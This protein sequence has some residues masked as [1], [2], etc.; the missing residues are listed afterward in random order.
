MT[1][2]RHA[3]IA[4]LAVALS[5]P[6]AGASA[7]ECQCRAN[8]SAFRQG[9]TTCLALPDGPRLARCEMV[10][11]NSS[12]KILDQACLQTSKHLEREN[13]MTVAHYGATFGG[14]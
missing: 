13:P 4:A 8:G 5:L 10:L 1:M 6:V 7:A 11:N 12:W 3:G 2:L 9:E 14:D